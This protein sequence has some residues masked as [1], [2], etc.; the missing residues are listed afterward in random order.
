MASAAENS[1]EGEAE[2]SSVASLF[3]GI[4][5]ALVGV[6]DN[7][8]VVG[9]KFWDLGDKVKGAVAAPFHADRPSTSAPES[10]RQAEWWN[11]SRSRAIGADT[12]HEMAYS[13]KAGSSS[14]QEIG[15]IELSIRKL[16]SPLTQFLPGDEPFPEAVVPRKHR[17]P[18]PSPTTEAIADD[19]LRT[20][21]TS[22]L[23]AAAPSKGKGTARSNDGPKIVYS[24][25]RRI[26]RDRSTDDA[27]AAS[28]LWASAA[29]SS[30]PRRRSADK[31]APL[32]VMDEFSEAASSFAQKTL[33]Q[34]TGH[35]L[36][37]APAVSPE[38]VRAARAAQRSSDRL[39]SLSSRHGSSSSSAKPPS[40]PLAQIREGEQKIDEIV[41]GPAALELALPPMISLP[42]PHVPVRGGKLKGLRGL[43]R[44]PARVHTII[45][46]STVVSDGSSRATTPGTS[47]CSSN[48]SSPRGARS[49][50]P[51]SFISARELGYRTRAGHGS[52][53]TNLRSMH[54]QIGAPAHA[55]HT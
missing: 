26:S 37:E 39:F 17:G 30:S 45:P 7:V 28:S 15:P 3:A 12:N 20:P 43:R 13:W 36:V 46:E 40:V 31:G 53:M 47:S 18:P 9:D 54:A 10:S 27:D 50:R 14:V 33:R 41:P 2:K 32:R 38:T 25:A 21:L 48:A 34:I 52:H 22:E 42:P 5:G 55:V 29:S 49:P 4:G 16:A 44:G 11:T 51:L 35:P 8:G 1:R 24:R 23:A 6:K 19:D